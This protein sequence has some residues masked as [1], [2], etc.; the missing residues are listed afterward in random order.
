MA[1]KDGMTRRQLAARARAFAARERHRAD[2][3]GGPL[4]ALHR[5]AAVIHDLDAEAH[6]QAAALIEGSAADADE[7]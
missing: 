5:Q 7:G 3:E 6:E 1:P 2:H 4:E